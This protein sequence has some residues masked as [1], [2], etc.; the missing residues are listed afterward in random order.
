[1]RRVEVAGR[2]VGEQ[3]RRAPDE[4][5]RD[6]HALALAAR[7]LG[8]RVASSRCDEADRVERLARPRPPLGLAPRRCRA[9]RSRR[10]RARSSRRAGRTAGR[11]SRSRAPAAP[12]AP[13]S[14]SFARVAARRRATVARGRPLERPH[15]VQQRRLARAGRPDDRDRLARAHRSATRRAAPRRR[16]GRSCARRRSSSRSD[17]T[18]VIAP[19]PPCR[20]RAARRP[21]TS[22]KS[23]A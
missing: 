4:R 23:S 2:L 3:D 22:T 5:P 18:A 15:H 11:R 9:A 12:P 20:P 10:C 21:S 17:G 8:R 7:E 14:P 19:S 16:P 6:R 1:M 13:R